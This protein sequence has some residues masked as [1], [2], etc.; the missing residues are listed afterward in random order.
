MPTPRLP[1]VLPHGPS[2]AYPLHPK[3][4]PE[5]LAVINKRKAKK[6]AKKKREQTWG[7]PEFF[8]AMRK[9]DKKA[10]KLRRKAK[11]KYSK[12]RQKDV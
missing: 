6:L 4:Q 5:R 8:A 9:H 7:T 3:T 10:D 12:K 11:L 1:S 2:H